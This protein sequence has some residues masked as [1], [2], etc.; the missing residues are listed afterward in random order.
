M[1]KW[2]AGCGAAISVVYRVFDHEAPIAAVFYVRD[3]VSFARTTQAQD[4]LALA[5]V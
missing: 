4:A 3:S 2:L 5:L 1:E